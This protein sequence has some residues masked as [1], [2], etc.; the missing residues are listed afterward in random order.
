MTEKDEKID[1]MEPIKSAA[2]EVASVIKKVLKLEHDHLYQD[3]PRISDDILKII[4]NLSSSDG[5]ELVAK[6][7]NKLLS[8]MEE[9]PDP[10]EI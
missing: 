8:E 5:M 2:P 9:S 10:N 3:R 1:P 4:K 6:T 7:M